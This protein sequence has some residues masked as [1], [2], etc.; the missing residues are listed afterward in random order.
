[1][2]RNHDE[3]AVRQYLLG[4]LSADSQRS[5]EE[6]LMTEDTA[7]EEVGLAEDELVDAYLAGR[8]TNEDR[9]RFEQHFL[10]TPERQSS[11]RFAKALRR[12]V[13]T[14]RV[15]DASPVGGSWSHLLSLPTWPT[16]IAAFAVLLVVVGGLWIY[17]T[18][19]TRPQ[20]FA[21]VTLSISSSNRAEGAAAT[22]LRMPLSADALRIN[23][24]LPDGASSRD[25]YR[26]E[27]EN[28]LGETR[29]VDVA[30]HDARSV[31]VVIPA[32]QVNRGQ[33]ALKLFA[34]AP[35]GSERRV[36][37]SYFLTIE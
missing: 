15:D 8:L 18:R 28:D 10:A 20:N 17:L 36:N 19:N 5:F 32:S 6:N 24:L 33:Y 29:S 12:Y 34:K 30:S 7:L 13:E 3:S 1:M 4:Q 11:L 2:L 22:R 21:T 16:R 31:T 27:L 35:D 9:E 26:V 23:L 14:N 25:G 37:G